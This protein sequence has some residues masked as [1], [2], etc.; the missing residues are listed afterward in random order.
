MIEQ[1]RRKEKMQKRIIMS[2]S[3]LAMS[4]VLASCSAGSSTDSFRISNDNPYLPGQEAKYTYNSATSVAITDLNYL[5]TQE[6]SKASHFANFVDPLLLHNEFGV[7][8]KC[9]AS[10]VAVKN[11][12]KVYEVT[13]KENVPWVRYDG[14]QYEASIKGVST[15]QFVSAD[16]FVTTAKMILNFA[17]SAD[18]YYLVTNF[19]EGAIEYYLATQILYNISNSTDTQWK[20]LRTDEAKAKKLNELILATTGEET[21]YT[22]AD[23]QDIV[24]FKRVGIEVITTPGSNGG[25][26][27][28]YTLK[29]PAA[30]FPTLLAYS[31]YLPSNSYFLDS[32]KVKKF[33]TALDKLLY[34]GPYRL[35]KSTE[36]A[37]EYT[38]NESY[39]NADKVHINT[40]HYQVITDAS[41]GWAR[42]EFEAGRI[43]GF[44]LATTDEVGWAKYITG[45]EGTGTIL[46]PYDP[47]VNSRDYD[48]IDYVYGFNINVNRASNKTNGTTART[49]YYSGSTSEKIFNTERALSIKEF[50][51]FVIDALDL[52]TYCKQYST[53]PVYQPQYMMNTYVPKG[54]VQDNDGNDY[55]TTHYYEAYARHTGLSVD[56]VATK[57]AQGQ[58]DG[59]Q[60][61]WSEDDDGL[62]QQRTAAEEA[63]ALYN[64]KAEVEG[65]LKITYPITL[66]YFSVWQDED[67]KKYD[68]ETIRSFNQRLN[69][70]IDFLDYT[71]PG[72]NKFVVVPTDLV[73][74]SNYQTITN[75]G[76]FDICAT[77]GWGP[78]YGDPM[79]YMNTFTVGGDWRSIFGFVGDQETT[80]YYVEDGELKSDNLLEYYTTLVNAADAEYQN[81][82]TRYD[83]FAE[84]EYYLLNELAIF[85]PL[86][87]RGQGRQC[88]VSKA[89][90]Y[91]TPT[92][93]YGLSSNRLDG[94]Y[95]LVNTITGEQRKAATAKYNELKAAY[96]Q[97]HGSINIY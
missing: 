15:K 7:L 42:E 90:G 13:V 4:A 36:T 49:S 76:M 14:T 1:T 57:L 28:R 21:S 43:D 63:I 86:T 25:G 71:N 48:Y 82:N 66:E 68:S 69:N 84:A 58:Y 23:W 16:D 50:R 37:I 30:Y 20:S 38:K 62:A 52:A 2:L 17:N 33:G 26:A 46:E 47:N 27:L 81:V 61:P 83:N 88:S 67:T 92:G 45:P 29:K 54:F 44:T 55:V 59:V 51:Q 39:W 8:E 96:L 65:T 11:D 79:S 74:T 89:A 94:L 87:M 53:D 35:T 31:P 22:G 41:V 78:D 64:A 12:Y 70:D 73:N 75:S 56:E 24:D 93:A 85:K 95:V 18:T 80:N 34:C 77:W 6:G 72:E 60:T 40:I 19:I 32:V 91:E 5:T 9:L 3:A 10:S 97:A